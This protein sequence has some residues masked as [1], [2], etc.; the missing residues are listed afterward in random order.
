ME[1]SLPALITCSI[2]MSILSIIIYIALRW[3]YLYQ[4]AGILSVYI[5]M[6]LTILRGCFPLDIYKPGLTKTYGSLVIIPT[7]QK[8][9]TTRIAYENHRI[10]SVLDLMII[11]WIV[12]GTFLFIKKSVGYYRL[13]KKI[14]QMP[15]SSSQNINQVYQKAFQ[16]I[17]KRK[18]Y[19]FEVIE[20]K[21]ISTPAT[22]GLFHPVI[23]L[24]RIEFTETELYCVLLHELIHIKHRDWVIKVIMDFISCIHWWNIF[25]SILLPSLLQQIQELYV[26]H[27]METL[28]PAQN[29]F[30][31]A[32]SILKTLKYTQKSQ[33]KMTA[34]TSYY[35]LCNLSNKKNLQQRFNY[36]KKWKHRKKSNI[37]IALA[38]ILFMF[39]FTFVFEAR[40]LPEYDQNGD[41]IFY[42]E[43]DNSYY[44]KNGKCYDLY[45]NGEYFFTTEDLAQVPNDFKDLPIYEKGDFK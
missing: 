41:D 10:F 5:L 2:S 18:N 12:V 4:K 15:R 40:N 26:D 39:S 28:V 33:K 35:A 24:P 36:I 9:I 20:M 8:I 42:L 45:L 7:I 22:F 29:R 44:L 3:N 25:V 16:K 6:I 37:F 23:L 14:S 1:L 21:E 11:V 32:S 43:K 30:D 19:H 13:S 34:Q 38:S 17:F 27:S 31:Y